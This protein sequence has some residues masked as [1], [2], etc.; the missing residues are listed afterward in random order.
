MGRTKAFARV[1]LGVRAGRE[2]VLLTAC[3]HSMRKRVRWTERTETMV[4]TQTLATAPTTRASLT[5][6][7]SSSGVTARPPP[8]GIEALT[9]QFTSGI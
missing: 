7:L 5:L 8:T 6:S 9:D 2:W 3:C 1:L 4:E